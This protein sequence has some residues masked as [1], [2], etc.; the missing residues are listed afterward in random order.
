MCEQPASLKARSSWAGRLDLSPVMRA[1]RRPLPE[2]SMRDTLAMKPARALARRASR[3][4]PKPR[5][6]R[7]A[8]RQKAGPAS[9]EPASRAG[10]L[11]DTL[12]ACPAQRLGPPSASSLILA[13]APARTNREPT[14]SM[15]SS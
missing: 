6:R 5:T 12:I 3:P 13:R 8:A 4:E 10:S 15:S 2:D 11:P 9:A 14:E 1:T 7:S